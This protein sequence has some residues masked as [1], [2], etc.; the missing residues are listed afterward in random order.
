MKKIILFT[1]LGMFSASSYAVKI[2][3]TLHGKG[4]TVIGQDKSVKICPQ[5]DP[6]SC[7]TIEVEVP[8][9]PLFLPTD[10]V[11]LSGYE[12]VITYLDGSTQ[13]V[14]MKNPTYGNISDQTGNIHLNGNKV[15]FFILD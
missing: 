5:E 13:N 14:V 10:V 6:A 1:I 12:G 2:K 8:L 3:I 15:E 11:P 4:G 7:A 9:P